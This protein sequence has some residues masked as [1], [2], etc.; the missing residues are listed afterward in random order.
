MKILF[1]MGLLVSFSSAAEN[2]VYIKAGTFWMGSPDSEEGR[3][4]NEVLHQETISH[5]FEIAANEVTQKEWMDVMGF[6]PSYFQAEYFCPK[7]FIRGLCPDL[8]VE[9]V[10][11]EDVQA[12]IDK[13]NQLADGFTYRLP[14]ESEWEY[15]A[16]AG[17]Q[18]PYYFGD[19]SNRL[20]DYEWYRD[21]SN[22]DTYYRQA[23]SVGA[24]QPNPWGLYDMLGNVSEWVQNQYEISE[25]NMDLYV[26]RGGSWVFDASMAR[27]AYRASDDKSN[28][29]NSQGFRLVRSR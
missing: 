28:R 21:N 25:P 6:N 16:R 24:K 8:P 5:D 13:K 11:W 14:T 10:S 3:F 19:N 2:Y 29:T 7:T 4:E 15:A 12:F 20:T 26:V 23:R 1:V 18:T 17:T 27:A 9:S 22:D